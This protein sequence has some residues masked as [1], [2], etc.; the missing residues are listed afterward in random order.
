MPGACRTGNGRMSDIDA[1]TRLVALI[2]SPV[3]HS[4]SPTIH[5]AAFAAAGLNI[6]YIA[7]DVTPIDLEAAVYGLRSLGA[8]GAN[9]TIPLKRDVARFVDSLSP[10]ARASGAVNTL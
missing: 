3:S 7:F 10:V 9:V 2:G 4:L 5:N 1:S 6:R 8:V